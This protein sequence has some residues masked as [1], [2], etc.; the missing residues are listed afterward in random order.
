MLSNFGH[1]TTFIALF[2]SRNKNLL[3]TPWAEILTHNLY[4][5]IYLF[6]E[7]LK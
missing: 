3:M 4:F 2:E 5:K 1:M 7:K 6:S